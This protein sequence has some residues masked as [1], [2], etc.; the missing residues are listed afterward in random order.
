MAVGVDVEVVVYGTFEFLCLCKDILRSIKRRK[1][2]VCRR[3]SVEKRPFGS[4]LST[5]LGVENP[6]RLVKSEEMR[7]DRKAKVPRSAAETRR[8]G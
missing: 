3:V 4:G 6:K 5:Y 1:L 2:Y 7:R 8:R